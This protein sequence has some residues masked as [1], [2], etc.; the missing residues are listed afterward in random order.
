[1]FYPSPIPRS[2]KSHGAEPWF[3]HLQNEGLGQ[4]TLKALQF[5]KPL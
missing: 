5:G 4:M 3:I 1:M 2:H